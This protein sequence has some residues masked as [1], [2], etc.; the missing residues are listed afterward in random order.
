V[1]NVDCESCKEKPCCRYH[2]WKVFFLEEERNL[3]AEKYGTAQAELISQYHSRSNGQSVYAVDLPCP[4][5]E[6]ATGHCKIYEARPFVCRLFP[7]EVEPITGTTYV[8]KGVCPK[9]GLIKSI[10][11]CTGIGQSV[12]LRSAQTLDQTL[13]KNQD[14]VF[15]PGLV[16][17]AVDEWS[18]KFWRGS[19]PQQP[20][21]EGPICQERPDQTY[22]NRCHS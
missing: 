12:V 4:F 21:Q 6:Q 16:Q 19:K 18:T 20:L 10:A 7:I 11:R 17:I 15:S 5:F 9:E 14:A 2:G 8:D 22:Q 1:I 3:V 13:P